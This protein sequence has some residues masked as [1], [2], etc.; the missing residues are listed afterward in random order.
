MDFENNTVK[1]R[2]YLP[3]G[4][5]NNPDFEIIAEFSEEEE[6][7]F[8][9]RLYT[10]GLFGIKAEYKA[11]IGVM[12]GSGW[13]MVINY[14]DGTQK[15]STGSNN[16]PDSVFEKCAKAFYDICEDGIVAHVPKE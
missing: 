14:S 6:V 5:N 1:S 11:P 3:S 15:K 4:G 12:D 13:S 9:N 2:A 16:S 10:Y 7:G 8:I